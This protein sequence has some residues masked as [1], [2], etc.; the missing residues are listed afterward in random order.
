VY[1]SG[2][3]EKGDLASA[4]RG[5]LESLEATLKHL[6][7]GRGDIVQL[8]AFLTPMADVAVA[9][10]EF[11]KFF[12]EGSVPPVVW[13]EWISTSPIEIE[14][15][16]AAD[17]PAGG[18]ETVTFSTPPGMKGSPV[19]SKVAH[20]RGGQRIYLSGLL[21]R[22]GQNGETQVK[23]VFAELD[24]LLQQ[25]G[26]DLKHLV[27]ATYY[28]SDNDASA[29]LNELRP[30]YYDPQRPPAASKAL[31]RGVGSPGRSLVVDLIAV[32]AK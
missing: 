32:S 16:A 31:V 14:L 2:Q 7:L 23:D 8:K 29:K 17:K 27:K 4:T 6:Q 5:T 11:A 26:S 22:A 13:V 24:G 3:A 10:R 21:G 15:V 28:V 12:G 30:R 18:G 1:V 19:Y 9:Q 25:A 20:L